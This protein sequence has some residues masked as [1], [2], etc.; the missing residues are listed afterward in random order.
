LLT[1]SQKHTV[2]KIRSFYAQRTASQVDLYWGTTIPLDTTHVSQL[3]L[4]TD[5]LVV[6][7]AVERS[8]QGFLSGVLP[9]ARSPLRPVNGSAQTKH[10]DTSEKE[11][12]PTLK[13]ENLHASFDQRAQSVPSISSTTKSIFE[14][15]PPI[16]S[17]IPGVQNLLLSR[18]QSG[19]HLGGVVTPEAAQFVE[20]VIQSSETRS[21]AHVLGRSFAPVKQETESASH[22]LYVPHSPASPNPA[23]SSQTIAT[24]AQIPSSSSL[25][26]LRIQKLLAD[27]TPEML[28]AEVKSSVRLL[29][30]L[31]SY[32][33]PFG[34]QSAEAHQWLQQIGKFYTKLNMRSTNN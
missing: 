5:Q 12:K 21:P 4:W 28:E 13:A 17:P 11:E 3:D 34:A 15:Y 14:A 2:A 18:L 1:A 30:Q 29:D 19:V 9:G 22:C 27:G 20:S 10:V 32:I 24:I 25:N 8:E 7:H 33:L 16:R 31:K 26:T 6:F 23:A